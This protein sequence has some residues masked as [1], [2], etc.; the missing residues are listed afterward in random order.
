VRPV[1]T[2][3][4]GE[5]VEKDERIGVVGAVR[6]VQ[7]PRRPAGA[8]LE[9]TFRSQ[10]VRPGQATDPH[11]AGLVGHAAVPKA[12]TSRPRE[13]PGKRHFAQPTRKW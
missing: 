10:R 9:P 4:R 13:R 5:A 11:G 6:A 8:T 2:G 7:A 1:R 3:A 12:G